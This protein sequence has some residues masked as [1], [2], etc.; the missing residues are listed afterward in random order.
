MPWMSCTDPAAGAAARRA[1]LALPAWITWLVVLRYLIGFQNRVLVLIRRAFSLVT[2][3]RGAR[4]ISPGA[5]RAGRSTGPPGA[6]P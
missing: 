5:G 3:G 4:L 1:G 6:A 2:R